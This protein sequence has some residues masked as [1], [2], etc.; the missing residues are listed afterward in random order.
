MILKESRR[1]AVTIF[2]FLLLKGYINRGDL[3]HT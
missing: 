1:L 2:V 3:L